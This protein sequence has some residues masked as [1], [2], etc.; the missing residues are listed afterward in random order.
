MRDQHAE[1]VAH[2]ETVNSL[3]FLDSEDGASVE[4]R[5]PF[6]IMR[7]AGSAE[8][9]IP[10]DPDDY[11]GIHEG[12]AEN[13]ADR[14]GDF[15]V[16]LADASIEVSGRIESVGFVDG[17]LLVRINDGNRVSPSEINV[18]PEEIDR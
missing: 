1:T 5:G 10:V 2:K 13:L 17:D 4:Y 18:D 9:A 15:A 12:T 14:V 3:A 8:V 6:A 7:D 11:A 16:A